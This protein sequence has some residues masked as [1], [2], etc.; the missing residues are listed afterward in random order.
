[1]GKGDEFGSS[2]GANSGVGF[3]RWDVGD[4]D[5]PQSGV[6]RVMALEDNNVVV[7]DSDSGS[8]KFNETAS[9]TKL[10]NGQQ[11]MGLQVGHDAD[12]ASGCRQVW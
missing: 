12:G 4:L 10:A 9:I 8:S 6:G 1:M 3:S 5:M 11:G 2:G 7:V